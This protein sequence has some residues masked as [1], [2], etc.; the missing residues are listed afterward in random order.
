MQDLIELL[1]N[2]AG[3]TEAQAHKSL[4]V[5]KEYIQSK[6]PPMMSGMVDNFLGNDFTT[7]DDDFYPGAPAGSSDK[8]ELIQK[9]TVVTKEATEKI[10][11]IAIEA[12]EE[13]EDF[14]RE[15]SEQID[16]WAEKAEE[17]A[18]EAINKL[19]DMMEEQE[20][21]KK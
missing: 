12:K 4:M 11:N 3:L 21:G 6:L 20:A 19:K 8:E 10:E 1:Q 2:K 17:A 7:D 9:A 13:V 16:K 18:Q 14:A 15:A 5:I